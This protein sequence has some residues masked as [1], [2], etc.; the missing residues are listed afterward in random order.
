MYRQWIL[1]LLEKCREA[2]ARGITRKEIR[3]DILPDLSKPFL[4]SSVDFLHWLRED[5]EYS[6]YY[7]EVQEAGVCAKPVE[8]AAMVIEAIVGFDS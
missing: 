6:F 4:E 2:E 8:I 7:F 1:E 3:F 5:R